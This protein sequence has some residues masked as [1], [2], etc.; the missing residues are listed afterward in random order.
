MT[1]EP[2]HSAPSGRDLSAAVTAELLWQT[3]LTPEEREIYDLHVEWLLANR[4]AD[5]GYCRRRFAADTI[6]FNTNG[7]VYRGVEHWCSLW[8][9]YRDKLVGDRRTGGQPP[10]CTS[11]DVVV[12]VVGD[13]AWVSYRLTSLVR[14]RSEEYENPWGEAVPALGRGTE[15]YERRDGR[16]QMV[17]GHYSKGEPG[18]DAGGL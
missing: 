15:V 7:S 1:S 10:L 17:H 13:V 16:W 5:T 4:T 12:R 9:F 6:Q 11:H 8:D 3:D 2:A 14:W 18:H